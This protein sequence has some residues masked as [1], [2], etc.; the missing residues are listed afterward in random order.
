MP[1]RLKTNTRKIRKKE[2]SVKKVK[3][4]RSQFDQETRDIFLTPLEDLTDSLKKEL[5]RKE[6]FD[7]AFWEFA[8]KEGLKFNRKRYS[9]ISPGFYHGEVPEDIKSLVSSLS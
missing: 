3:T 4:V 8:K 7:A 1:K 2:K 5:I 6:M 9:F